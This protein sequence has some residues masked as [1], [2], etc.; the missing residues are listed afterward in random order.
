MTKT[1]TAVLTLSVITA[2]YFAIRM[3]QLGYEWVWI[4]QAPP[5]AW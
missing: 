1:V 5:F 2:T 3:I 4:W